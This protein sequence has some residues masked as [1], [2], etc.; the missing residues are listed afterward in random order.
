MTTTSMMDEPQL[1]RFA[2]VIAMTKLSKPSIYK[3]MKAGTFPRPKHVGRT[4][5]WRLADVKAW[6][7]SE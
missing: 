5:L 6:I 7:E 1:L 3:H 2:T 4:P